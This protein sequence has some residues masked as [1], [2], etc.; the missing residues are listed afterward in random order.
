M[1]LLNLFLLS[2]LLYECR[3]DNLNLRRALDLNVDKT[4][5]DLVAS[6]CL[7]V[8]VVASVGC[9]GGNGSSIIFFLFGVAELGIGAS[10][11]QDGVVSFG[12]GGSRR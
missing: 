8:A 5:G 6:I 3:R 2:L 4:K 10:I 11:V 1:C 7:A 9:G 12:G